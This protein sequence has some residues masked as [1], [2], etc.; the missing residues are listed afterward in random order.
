MTAADLTTLA[1]ERVQGNAWWVEGTLERGRANG[2]PDCCVKAFIAH[3]LVSS[4]AAAERYGVL[5]PKGPRWLAKL[6]GLQSWIP[7]DYHRQNPPRGY[8]WDGTW[9]TSNA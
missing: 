4:Q 5:V 8:R 9:A 1:L 7:C 2:Y 3:Y 6:S